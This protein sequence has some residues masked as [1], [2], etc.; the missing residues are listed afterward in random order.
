MDL[1]VTHHALE[2]MGLARLQLLTYVPVKIWA[3]LDGQAARNL[4]KI[5]KAMVSGIDHAKRCSLPAYVEAFKAA[6]YG[7]GD[8]WLYDQTQGNL[9]TFRDNSILVGKYGTNLI[10][11]T[12]LEKA[13]RKLLEHYDGPDDWHSL[14]DFS[15]IRVPYFLVPKTSCEPLPH[16]HGGSIPILF[17]ADRNSDVGNAKPQDQS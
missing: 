9:F 6:R 3:T 11:V 13:K 5:L 16:P 7:L 10:T 17:E 2:R 15:A 4:R 8:V 12:H 1:H 14:N